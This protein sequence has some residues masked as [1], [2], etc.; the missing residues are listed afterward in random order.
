MCIS[1]ILPIS[2]GNMQIQAFGCFTALVAR[3]IYIF[4]CIGFYPINGIHHSHGVGKDFHTKSLK[5]WWYYQTHSGHRPTSSDAMLMGYMYV[6]N[7]IENIYDIAYN[8]DS[9]AWNRYS[10]AW[11]QVFIYYLLDFCLLICAFAWKSN[12][13]TKL[14]IVSSASSS[15]DIF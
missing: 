10:C 15:V 7:D 14:K 6:P 1:K 4:I 8:R 9:G 2:S 5:G 3:Y 12:R 11:M 13:S